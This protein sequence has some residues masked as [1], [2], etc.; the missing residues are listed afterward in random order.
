[1]TY[2]FSPVD[3]P[4]AVAS[5]GYGLNGQAQVVGGYRDAAGHGHG[6]LL[7]DGRITT[8]DVPGAGSTTASGINA[9]GQIVGSYQDAAG[10]GHGFLY[11]NG[12]F[13]RIDAPG[14]TDTYLDDIND[15]GEIVGAA[16]IPAGHSIRQEV[17]RAAGGRF[18]TVSLPGFVDRPSTAPGGTYMFAAGINNHGEIGV[19]VKMAPGASSFNMAFIVAGDGSATSLAPPAD[20]FRPLSIT[21]LD[22]QRDVVGS[23]GLTPPHA[24]VERQGV[25]TDITTASGAR[26]GVNDINNAGWIVGS[27]TGSDGQNHAFLASP[28]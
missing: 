21:A 1:M 7:A 5:W 19:N 27:A 17:F 4:G 15:S 16:A 28:A 20:A 2:V 12:R 3:V 11:E 6:F 8:L 26:P 13:T 10:V 18:T 22:D 25:I 9:S 23:Y 24:F 14:A